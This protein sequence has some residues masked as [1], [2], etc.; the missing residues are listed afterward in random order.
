MNNVDYYKHDEK[1]DANIVVYS[2]GTI[3]WD[4]SLITKSSCPMNV[5]YFPFDS[6]TC[7]N[8]RR[9]LE[10][11]KREFLNFNAFLTFIHFRR[12]YF[13]NKHLGWKYTFASWSYPSGDMLLVDKNGKGILDDLNSN[14]EWE[15]ESMPLEQFNATYSCCPDNG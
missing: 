3:V 1:T 13:E 11:L 8:L 14:I 7:K 5:R 6:Q 10:N 2:D 15:V 4:Q 12:R 9:K